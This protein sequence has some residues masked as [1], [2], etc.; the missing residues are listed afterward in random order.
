MNERPLTA[1]S[2]AICDK[3]TDNS[4]DSVIVQAVAGSGKTEQLKLC[5]ERTI[6]PVAAICFGRDAKAELEQ[7]MPP[8]AT[9]LTFNAKGNRAWRAHTRAYRGLGKD[10][11]VSVDKTARII[12][13]L[14]EGGKIERNLPLGRIAKLVGL[15]KSEGLVPLEVSSTSGCYEM[16]GL[17]EDTP[18]EWARIIDHYGIETDERLTAD[19]LIGAAKRVLVESIRWSSKIIDYDDQL[20][21][22]TL[23]L[24]CPFSKEFWLYVDELQDVSALQRDMI[25]KIMAAGGRLLGVGDR[26]QAIYGWRGADTGSMDKI[27][28]AT[29]AV[30]L[31]LSICWRCDRAIVELAQKIV[32]QIL[33][34]PGADEGLVEYPSKVNLEVFQA[35]SLL[36]CRNRAPTIRLAYKL[37][38][39]GAPVRMLGSN[40]C[41]QIVGRIRRLIGDRPEHSTTTETLLELSERE[42][43]R[44]IARANERKDEDAVTQALENHEVITALV[45]G[46]NVSTVGELLMWVADLYSSAKESATVIRCGTIHAVKGLQAPSV[47]VLDKHLMPSRGA[48]KDWQIQQE[49]N[50]EYVAITRAKH[51]LRFI[52]SEDVHG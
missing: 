11:D 12:K 30:E 49:K 2:Q 50:L 51:E 9:C 27:K 14:K 1:F 38:R 43:N 48:K 35:G 44:V 36:V 16:R 17:V 37:I 25:S 20:Y 33:P 8:N 10:L 5:A 6:G 23:T 39:R 45:E 24:G 41:D 7:R 13:W 21:M 28:A 19:R 3:V 52:R 26:H 32:P 4:G 29:S 47:W 34:R 40:Q 22:P 31:P 42:T 15:A 46:I 18:Q